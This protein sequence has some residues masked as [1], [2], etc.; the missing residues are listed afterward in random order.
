MTALLLNHGWTSRAIKQPMGKPPCE[1]NLVGDL[2]ITLEEGLEDLL[3]GTYS[4]I[5]QHQS[6]S[7]RLHQLGEGPVMPSERQLVDACSDVLPKLRCTMQM[8]QLLQAFI[9]SGL[10]CT[11]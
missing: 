5:E 2:N 1:D 4:V 6:L 9:R 7:E 10:D 3:L 11:L 8:L